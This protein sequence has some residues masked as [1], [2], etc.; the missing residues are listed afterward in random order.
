MKIIKNFIKRS[1][2]KPIYTTRIISLLGEKT[3]KIVHEEKAPTEEA[4]AIKYK[5]YNHPQNKHGYTYIDESLYFPSPKVY[6][7]DDVLLNLDSGVNA[8]SSYDL[9]LES[10]IGLNNLKK[11]GAY[12]VPKH[13][14]INLLPK[15]I[16]H[17]TI[18]TS[19]AN[20]SFY[21]WIIDC[22]PR[23]Y[24]LSKLDEK[25]HLVFPSQ[26]NS[27][28]KKLLDAN[29]PANCTYEVIDSPPYG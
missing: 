7:L 27:V 10:A 8:S 23:L 25:I 29:L 2:L 26:I 4:Q 3:I 19:S 6:S 17:S 22:L 16:L 24:L 12:I 13:A 9:I 18:W 1:L 15:D 5:A 28:Q 21:H 20:Q 14:P 11:S